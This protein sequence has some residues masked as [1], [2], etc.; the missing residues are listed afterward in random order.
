MIVGG[1]EAAGRLSET[2]ADQR[3]RRLDT[4]KDQ[5]GAQG[6]AGRDYR[7]L[8]ADP[9]V[10]K[11]V[12]TCVAEL[13]GRLNRWE[14]IRDFRIM[15]HDLSVADDELTPTTKMRRKLIEA[16]FRRLLDSMY[17]SRPGD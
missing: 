3:G 6:L 9:A 1:D 11:Y 14:T 16:R 5:P 10:E 13:T 7:S 2:P 15:D 4:A 12:R 17:Q 8:A